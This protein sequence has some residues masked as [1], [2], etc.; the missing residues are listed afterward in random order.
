MDKLSEETKNNTSLTLNICLN[1]GS[2]SEIVDMTKKVSEMVKNNI[3]KVEDIDEEVIK[4]NL[5][6][7]LPPLDYVIRT[8]GELRLSNFMMYQASYAEFYFPKV[9]FP[10]FNREEF[11]KALEEY[12]KRNRRFGGIK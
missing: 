12:S 6:Q 9:Y 5:Y 3:I 7:D 11:D 8:S 4:K 1:Y 10:D 2:C